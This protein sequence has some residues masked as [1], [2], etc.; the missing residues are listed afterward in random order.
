VFDLF[1]CSA[2]V[3]KLLFDASWKTF[4]SALPTLTIM[5]QVPAICN[6]PALLSILKQEKRVTK[7]E[8]VVFDFDLFIYSSVVWFWD[9]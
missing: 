6:F 2:V 3:V 9:V 8:L 5:A 4:F 7:A 1:I